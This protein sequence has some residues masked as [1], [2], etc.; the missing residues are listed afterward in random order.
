MQSC[1]LYHQLYKAIIFLVCLKIQRKKRQFQLLR[2]IWCDTGYTI[3]PRVIQCYLGF[4]FHKNPHYGLKL[5][6]LPVV[7]WIL[8]NI[9]YVTECDHFLQSLEF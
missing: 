7:K 9:I 6:C 4:Q 5:K 2:E 8:N 1:Y 3:H